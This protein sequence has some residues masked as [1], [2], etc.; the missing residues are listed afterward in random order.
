MWILVL[1]LIGV[2]GALIAR[3]MRAGSNGSLLSD[4]DQPSNDQ[5]TPP[6]NTN[7][8][9]WLLFQTM[10]QGQSSVPSVDTSSTDAPSPS[11][12]GGGDSSSS[13]PEPDYS[14]SSVVS[15]PADDAGATGFDSGGGSGGSD[16][17][18]FAGGGGDTF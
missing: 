11:F 6:A 1:L 12:F 5:P 14:D 4:N 15:S 13:S 3:A 9:N 2:I 18:G 17:G 7:S 10:Q 16:G 8:A